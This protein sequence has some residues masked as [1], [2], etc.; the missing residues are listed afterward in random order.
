M[1]C[2]ELK[3]LGQG[4]DLNIVLRLV[5]RGNIMGPRLASVSQLRGGEEDHLGAEQIVHFEPPQYL[6]WLEKL[7]EGGRGERLV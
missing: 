4:V 7:R 5:Y 1:C 6:Q 3:N 2:G